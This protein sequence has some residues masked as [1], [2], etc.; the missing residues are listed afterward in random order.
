MEEYESRLP[1]QQDGTCNG[2]QHY[3]ALGGDESGAAAVN[4]IGANK[5]GDVYGAVA[6]VVSS[7]V[8]Q[9]AANGDSLAQALQGKITRKTVKQTVM[10]TVYGEADI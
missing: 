1:V 8:D 10:T 9:D 4:L 3:A 5:P 2:L 7:L 6:Q